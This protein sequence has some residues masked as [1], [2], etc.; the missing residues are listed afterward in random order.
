MFIHVLCRLGE[1]LQRLPDTRVG[2][3]VCSD[4]KSG[5]QGQVEEEDSYVLDWPAAML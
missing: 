5:D 2:A 4:V 3:N 1:G